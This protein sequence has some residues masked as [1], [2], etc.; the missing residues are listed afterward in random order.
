V[1]APVGRFVFLSGYRL[2][3]LYGQTAS[4]AKSK[5]GE[6]RAFSFRSSRFLLV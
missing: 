5:G 2:D 3:E 1:V 4:W 6:V